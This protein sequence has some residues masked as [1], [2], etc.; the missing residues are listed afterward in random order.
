MPKMILVLDNAEKGC[1]YE[2]PLGYVD[3]HDYDCNPICTLSHRYDECPL[4]PLP[5]K[6]DYE[7]KCVDG[8]LAFSN[9]RYADGWNDCIDEIVGDEN[10]IVE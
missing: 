1:C 7:D 4:K 2:C 10:E 9:L 8:V 3:I 6:K 5:K